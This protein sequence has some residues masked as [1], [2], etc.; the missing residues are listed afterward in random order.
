MTKLVDRPELRKR[1]TARELLELLEE[2]LAY[3]HYPNLEEN[4]DI[5]SFTH[6]LKTVYLAPTNDSVKESD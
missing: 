3:I 1:T 5:F 4:A 2:Y 6:W